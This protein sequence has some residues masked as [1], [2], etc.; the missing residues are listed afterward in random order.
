MLK[1]SRVTGVSLKFSILS[2]LKPVH[3]YSTI[4]PLPNTTNYRSLKSRHRLDKI[5]T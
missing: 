4:P 3:K 5:Q 1:R 2:P